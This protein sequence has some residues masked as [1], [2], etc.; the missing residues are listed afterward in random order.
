MYKYTYMYYSALVFGEDSFFILSNT[1]DLAS[2]ICLVFQ[3]VFLPRK[4]N[5]PALPSTC[6][7]IFHKRRYLCQRHLEEFIQRP[8]QSHAHNIYLAN[9][10]A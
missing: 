10:K 4:K 7:I 9:V 8:P 3:L 1:E 2:I 5:S 6:T